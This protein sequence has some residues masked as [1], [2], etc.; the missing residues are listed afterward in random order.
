MLAGSTAPEINP[1]QSGRLELAQWITG[2]QNTLTARV[3]VNRIWLH[4]M[5]RPLVA[6]PDNFGVSGQLPSHPE[7][8]DKLATRLMELNWSTDG[9]IREIVLS[10]AWGLSNDHQAAAYA[11]IR[12]TRCIGVRLHAGCPRRRFET[13]C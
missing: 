12:T 6:T 13:A 11:K 8:L 3:W 1:N 2:T 5:G 7:L 9:L 10:R 4:L